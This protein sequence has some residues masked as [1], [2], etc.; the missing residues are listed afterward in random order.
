MKSFIQ[1]SACRTI[2]VRHRFIVITILYCVLSGG[3]SD[4]TYP[5]KYSRTAAQRVDPNPNTPFIWKMKTSDAYKETEMTFR[6]DLCIIVQKKIR[7]Y[8]V[9]TV[10][11]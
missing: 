10:L 2:S 7:L 1:P 8:A 11:H 6:L 4:D 3:C 5:G 9:L